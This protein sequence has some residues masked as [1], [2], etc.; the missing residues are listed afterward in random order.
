[1]N[2]TYSRLQKCENNISLCTSIFS[3]YCNFKTQRSTCR[4]LEFGANSIT[5]RILFLLSLFPHIYLCIF[6]SLDSFVFNWSSATV[7]FI[8]RGG[9]TGSL[10]HATLS[11]SDDVSARHQPSASPH[12]QLTPLSPT[13]NP[14]CSSVAGPS[15]A[16]FSSSLSSAMFYDAYRNGAHHH[17]SNTA[18]TSASLQQQQQPQQQY[19]ASSTY[20]SHTQTQLSPPAYASG[21]SSTQLYSALPS[22]TS[23]Q[24]PQ[25]PY[26]ASSSTAA[27]AAA[28]A[29][30]PPPSVPA[31][32][33]ALTST[34]ASNMASS[35]SPASAAAPSAVFPLAALSALSSSPAIATCTQASLATFASSGSG[36]T[37]A[38]PEQ[39]LVDAAMLELALH[40]QVLNAS[41]E[42]LYPP[43][44]ADPEVCTLPYYQFSGI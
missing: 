15:G 37:V 23:Q 22:A 2:Y 36:A 10:S 44:S 4:S 27:A 38:S 16:H 31:M 1:M 30:V 32:L 7:A 24:Q 25:P 33:Y 13:P 14:T 19:S 21:T 3:Y 11:T 28:A 18:T 41:F 43:T 42:S 6:S 29:S 8:G 39:R 12:I 40:L 9:V 34:M 5:V 26:S 35:A 20:P 17:S